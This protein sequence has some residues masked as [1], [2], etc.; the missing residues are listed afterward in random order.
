MDQ[1]RIAEIRAR[2]QALLADAKARLAKVPVKIQVIGGLLLLAAVFMAIYTVM[3][4]HDA[5]LRLK[6]QHSF[7]SAGLQVFVDDDRVYSGKLVGSSKKKLF[8]GDS[9]QGNLSET[10]HVPSGSRRVRVRVTADDGTIQEDTINAEFSR[11]AEHTLSVV[12]RRS[13]VALSWQGTPVSVP[14]PPPASPGW[15][16]RYASALFLTAAGSIISALTGYA[17]KELPGHLRSRQT[18]VDKVGN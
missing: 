10:L 12:A 11:N 8:F 16:S 15:F 1:E 4:S 3:G 6:V 17:V 14:D 2:A 18:T 9:V 7:R 13:D 5:T